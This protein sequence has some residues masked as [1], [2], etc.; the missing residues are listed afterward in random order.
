MLAQ[1]PLAACGKSLRN[2]RRGNF[3][4]W[5]SIFVGQPLLEMLYVREWYI[6]QAK[7]ACV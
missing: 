1:L 5:L 7:V 4:V 6:A 3:L 2:T